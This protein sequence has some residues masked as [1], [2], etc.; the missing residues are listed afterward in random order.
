M[1]VCLILL[2]F[3]MRKA[4]RNR[5]KKSQSRGKWNNLHTE[6][7]SAVFKL[8]QRSAVW[9]T[10][11]CPHWA[12]QGGSDCSL[13]FVQPP[14]TCL[15][16]SCGCPWTGWPWR[17]SAAGCWPRRSCGGCRWA[18]SCPWARRG[19]A[20]RPASPWSSQQTEGCN[21]TARQ[22]ARDVQPALSSAQPTHSPC[23]DTAGL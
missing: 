11:S 3:G 12:A 9:H 2:S 14:L 7:T 22:T 17:G 6:S 10:T 5:N 21:R 8:S 16:C 18:A 15:A 1:T 20:A 19:S 13:S 23:A 4:L